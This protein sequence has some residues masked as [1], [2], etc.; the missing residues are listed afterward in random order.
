MLL[1]PSEER[2]KK[3]MSRVLVSFAFLLMF[4]GYYL[5]AYFF[6]ILQLSTLY[7]IQRL[8]PVFFKRFEQL[9]LEYQFIREKII[10]QNTNDT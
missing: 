5:Y 2:K 7:D 9:S 1:R 4:S 8:S 10:A 6:H 3:C